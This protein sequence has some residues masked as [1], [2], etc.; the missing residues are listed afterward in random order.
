[1]LIDAINVAKQLNSNGISR[2]QHIVGQS[3]A[4]AVR[5]G[6][7][8]V[9]MHGILARRGS[10]LGGHIQKRVE[11]VSA[12]VEH[13]DHHRVFAQVPVDLQGRPRLLLL[14]LSGPG[15]EVAPGCRVGQPGRQREQVDGRVRDG[16][17]RSGSQRSQPLAADVGIGLPILVEGHQ[18]DDRGSRDLGSVN[19]DRARDL[20]QRLQRHRVNHQDPI[21]DIIHAL[22]PHGRSHFSAGRQSRRG[23]QVPPFLIGLHP[24]P[25]V[26]EIDIGDRDGLLQPEGPGRHQVANG[27]LTV[28]NVDDPCQQEHPGPCPHLCCVGR[29]QQI[30]TG[31]RQEVGHTGGGHLAPLHDVQHLC[32]LCFEIGACRGQWRQEGRTWAQLERLDRGYKVSGHNST[33]AGGFG[34]AG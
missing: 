30:V 32:Q 26:S 27:D 25:P 20:E 2:A 28:Y 5:Q 8:E 17:Q 9:Y 14:W 21:D 22:F 33:P 1:M 34:S 10:R 23:R 4:G 15:H 7:G 3:S 16:R 18:A 6:H 13:R 12:P 11:L 19:G 24:S 29:Q 31:A